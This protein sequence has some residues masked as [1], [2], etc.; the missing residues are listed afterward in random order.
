MDANSAYPEEPRME[1]L[2]GKIVMMS[3]PWK[4]AKK[5]YLYRSTAISV[6]PWRKSFR[7]CFKQKGERQHMQRFYKSEGQQHFRLLPF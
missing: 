4:K 2:N 1:L 6:S 3:S 5:R 7:I